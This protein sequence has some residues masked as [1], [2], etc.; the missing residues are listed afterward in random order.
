VTAAEQLLARKVLGKEL[1]EEAEQLVRDCTESYGDARGSEA[2]RRNVGGVMFRRAL[3]VARRRALGEQVE[4]GG[5][6]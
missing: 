5:G 1:L 6:H 2:Y 3:E 4:V